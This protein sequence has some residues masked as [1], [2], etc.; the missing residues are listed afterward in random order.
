[1]PARRVLASEWLERDDK[2]RNQTIGGYEM[3]EKALKRS[4]QDRVLF[5]VAGGLGSYL[6]IDPVLVRLFFVLLTLAGGHGV[7]IYVVLALLMPE[8]KVAPKANGFDPEEIII[9]DAV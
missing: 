5:G 4:S 6:N 2:K 7:L 1:L 3:N 9:K 8:E